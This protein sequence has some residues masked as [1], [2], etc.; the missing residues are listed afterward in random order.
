MPVLNST[1]NRPN[2]I[3]DD[4]QK[5][6]IPTDGASVTPS[7]NTDLTNPGTLYVGSQG[8]LIINTLYGTQLTFVNAFGFL[9]VNVSRVIST[10]TTATNILVLY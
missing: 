4:F 3:K 10:G 7:D 6:S 9:P 1:S 2:Y 8:T 5:L